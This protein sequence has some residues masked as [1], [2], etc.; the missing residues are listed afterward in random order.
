MPV[1][2]R[3]VE[4]RGSTEVFITATPA[5]ERPAQQQ[6][7]ELF[8][9]IGDILR[10]TDARLLEERIFATER[11]M[12]AVEPL[13][14]EAYRDLD[15]GVPPARLAV[16]KGLAGELAGVQVHAIRS[17]R[18]PQPLRFGESAC[19]RILEGAGAGPG[20][21]SLSG[22]SAPEAGPDPGAQTRA[23][24]ERAEAALRQV[25]VDMHAVARTWLWLGDILSWYGDFNRV[26]NAFFTERG[27]LDGRAA[28]NRPP[29]STGIGIRLAG[30]ARCGLDLIAIPGGRGSTSHHRA[31]GKQRCPYE[32]GSAFSR[33]T[34]AATPA[35]RTVF[36]AGTAAIDAQGKTAHVGEAGA[37]I[38]MTVE[39][40]RAV[41]KDLRCGDSD[42]VQAIAYSKTVEI[43]G[44]LR[45]RQ[46]SLPWPCLSTIADICR[47]DLLFELEVTAC[48]GARSLP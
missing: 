48:L 45:D 11:A 25:G 40:V 28:A 12:A 3:T 46:R 15:D 22:L 16:P 29:A 39:N 47:E 30:G 34:V 24:F 4:S 18:R 35:G 6:A 10:A 33:A 5:P 42:V 17:S 8:A 2:V 41:L 7:T 14:A 31:A 23:V 21:V 26:R 44:L 27:L 13:R 38:E 1:D 32:Y 43:E 20:Y 36:V 9:S 19:G 37:Q